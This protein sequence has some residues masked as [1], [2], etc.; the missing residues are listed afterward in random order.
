MIQMQ[1]GSSV[2]GWWSWFKDVQNLELQCHQALLSGQSHHPRPRLETT[3]CQ[4]FLFR[5]A[6]SQIS[7]PPGVRHRSWLR[8]GWCGT[9]FLGCA[10]LERGWCQT[11]EAGSCWMASVLRNT[12]LGYTAIASSGMAR[13][14]TSG[15]YILIL[16]WILPPLFADLVGRK[17]MIRW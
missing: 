11:Y 5:G 8:R 6:M 1:P 12:G 3:L 4:L 2:C 14:L 9:D 16:N 10:L 15:Y 17:Q 13:E 7:W